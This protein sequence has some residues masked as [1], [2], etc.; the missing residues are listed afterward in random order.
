MKIA[1]YGWRRDRLDHRDYMY[2]PTAIALPPA[3]DLHAKAPPIYDQ[4]QLGSC[5]ANAIAAAF[6][7]VRGKEGLPFITPSRLFIYFNERAIEGT[8]GVDAGAEIRDGLHTLG[9]NGVCTEADW[10]YDITKFADEP[11]IGDFTNALEH[12]AY[13]YRSIDG[14]A[15]SVLKTCLASGLPFVF[16]FSVFQQFENIDPATIPI[17]EL[18]NPA[19]EPIGGH[20]VCAV[21][22]DNAMQAVLCRNSWGTGWGTGW[23]DPTLNGHFW[24]PYTYITDSD[25]CADFW[26]VTLTSKT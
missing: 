9:W 19:D 26:T 25:L 24:M 3:V 22:Y 10:P 7:F 6:D 21:G 15:L 8:V 13:A 2:R 23:S 1:R 4:G 5:T 11:P 16:G 18:P 14:T 17:V 20:A 12:R